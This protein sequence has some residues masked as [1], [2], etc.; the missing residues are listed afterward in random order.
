MRDPAEL[1]TKRGTPFIVIGSR[2]LFAAY[3]TVAVFTIESRL[4]PHATPSYVWVI[5]LLAIY[6]LLER[7]YVFFGH[8][9]IDLAFAFPLLLAIYV[10][11]FVSVSL[12]AQE[13]I[14]IINRA[15]HLISFVLLSYV[16]WTFFLKYLPQ[17]VWHRHPYYTALIVVSITSTFGVIN[18]LAELF[19]D[20]LFGT[21]FIGRDSDT[22][23]DL[24]MNSLGAGLFLSVRLI[25]GA[26]DQDQSRSLAPH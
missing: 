18:E 21:T 1:Y 13:R 9:N 20:A 4:F 6:Y 19:F 14:P 16:V 10:F 8:K 17:R 3:F 2:L 12:N 11:N 24:L 25:L 26:R 23:L 22:A 5:Y 15:E 7:I